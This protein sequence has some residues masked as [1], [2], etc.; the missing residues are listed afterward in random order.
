MSN[1]NQGVIYYN[2][3]YFNVRNGGFSAWQGSRNIAEDI[4]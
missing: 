3:N 1:L 4:F 2:S